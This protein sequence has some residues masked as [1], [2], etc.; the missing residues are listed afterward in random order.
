M[1]REP[2]GVHRRVRWHVRQHR[3]GPLGH[4]EPLVL[5]RLIALFRRHLAR[6]DQLPDQPQ[7]VLPGEHARHAREAVEADITLGLR[8]RVA[9]EAVSLEQRPDVLGEPSIKLDR[10]FVRLPHRDALTP[11]AARDERQ[12]H[13]RNE[14]QR[15]PE[16]SGQTDRSHIHVRPVYRIAPGIQSRS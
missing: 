9:L 14:P 15:P 3:I 11:R 1:D 2:P 7:V 8:P 6:R 12:R 5:A 4:D 10:Q 16:P 13:R